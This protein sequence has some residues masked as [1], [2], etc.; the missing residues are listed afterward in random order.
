MAYYS[1]SKFGRASLGQLLAT[2]H[3]SSLLGAVRTPSREQAP[4]LHAIRGPRARTEY[5]QGKHES[6]YSLPLGL[7]RPYADGAVNKHD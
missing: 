3:A 5:E 6:T 2:Q 4:M 1:H 7:L